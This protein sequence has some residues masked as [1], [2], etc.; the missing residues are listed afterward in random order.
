MIVKPFDICDDFQVAQLA[1]A[2]ACKSLGVKGDCL[3]VKTMWRVNFG[4]DE[5]DRKEFI[6]LC[7][8]FINEASE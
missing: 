1:F 8:H 2:L 3:T 4:N 5:R 7:Q 6:E